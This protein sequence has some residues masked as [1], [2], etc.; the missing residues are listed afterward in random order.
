MRHLTKRQLEVVTVLY[1][2]SRERDSLVDLDQLLD[3]LSWSP[4]K[5]S[6]QFIVRAL[7]EKKLVAKAGI[8][9]RRGR[10]RVCYRL[11]DDGKLI[12]D[13]RSTEA[14]STEHEKDLDIPSIP[15]VLDF[16]DLDELLA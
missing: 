9:G 1:S 13:P 2:A 4:S 11:T 12:L 3:L 6:V 5:E 15:G 7:V 10:N 8:Q 14:L 16:S